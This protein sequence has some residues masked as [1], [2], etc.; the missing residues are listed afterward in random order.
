MLRRVAVLLV[1]IGAIVGFVFASGTASAA[2]DDI[3]N[4]TT[5]DKPIGNPTTS[6][7]TD[8]PITNPTT[9]PAVTVSEPT[10]TPTTSRTSTSRRV[11]TSSSS[12][13]STTLETKKAS[14]T[15]GGAI[16]LLVVLVA[17]IGAVLIGVFLRMRRTE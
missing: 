16:A 8:K 7:T 14:K 2:P 9:G 12:S 11:T 6:P 1:T 17:A 13:T 5:T 15:N 4:P 10:T 3:A